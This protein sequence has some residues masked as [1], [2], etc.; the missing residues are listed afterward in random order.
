[1]RE[2]CLL[3]KTLLRKLKATLL[4]AGYGGLLIGLQKII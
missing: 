1:M 2:G 3:F 4:K